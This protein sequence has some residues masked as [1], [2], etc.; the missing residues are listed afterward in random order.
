MKRSLDKS[1]P[2]D[3]YLVKKFRTCF[4]N[5]FNPLDCFEVRN[6]TDTNI[7]P[8]GEKKEITTKEQDSLVDKKF[9]TVIKENKNTNASK[10][11][12]QEVISENWI[13]TN[14]NNNKKEKP[15]S[16]LEKHDENNQTT[17]PIANNSKSI[18]KPKKQKNIPSEIE[19]VT[20]IPNSDVT[21]LAEVEIFSSTPDN[22]AVLKSQF[23]Q[24]L[25]ESGCFTISQLTLDQ[26]FF[27]YYSLSPDYMN[28]NIMLSWINHKMTTRISSLSN[29]IKSCQNELSS[30]E[31]DS[32][33]NSSRSNVSNEINNRV[34]HIEQLVKHYSSSKKAIKSFLSQLHATFKSYIKKNCIK[35]FTI[36]SV[37]TDLA[38]LSEALSSNFTTQSDILKFL[39]GFGDRLP[40]FHQQEGLLYFFWSLFRPHFLVGKTCI[41]MDTMG[42]GKT[43]QA[44]LNAK[45][46]NILLG[47]LNCVEI[48]QD[49]NPLSQKFLHT[50]DHQF[51]EIDIGN[52]FK[53]WMSS[54]YETN[55]KHYGIGNR[56]IKLPKNPVNFSGN[57]DLY[58]D[59]LYR[60]ISS[61]YNLN[62]EMDVKLNAT[63]NYLTVCSDRQVK[64]L[65]Q[66]LS[67]TNEKQ[68]EKKEKD[69]STSV[70]DKDDL[71]KLV[72]HTKSEQEI[73][74]LLMK[75]ETAKSDTNLKDIMGTTNN[76]WA[77]ISV[78]L[79]GNTV[80]DEINKDNDFKNT[81]EEAA[82][83]FNK[84][85]YVET[86]NMNQQ[87]IA[88][89]LK[90]QSLIQKESEINIEQDK[91]NDSILLDNDIIT[92][93]FNIN[94]SSKFTLPWMEIDENTKSYKFNSFD[95]KI[96]YIQNQQKVSYVNAI[97]TLFCSREFMSL[98]R[99]FDGYVFT[100][101]PLLAKKISQSSFNLQEATHT[102][103]F[104]E[105]VEE[106]L[107]SY[108]ETLLY[109]RT[110]VWDTFFDPK[111]IADIPPLLIVPLGSVNVWLEEI[112]KSWDKTRVGILNAQT[113]K[114]DK[115]NDASIVSSFLDDKFVVK[116]GNDMKMHHKLLN[117]L[118][119]FKSYDPDVCLIH[120][121]GVKSQ[122]NK[123]MEQ[124][125]YLLHI[126]LEIIQELLSTNKQ[127]SKRNSSNSSS[128]QSQKKADF[129]FIR[130]KIS[131][132][133]FAYEIRLITRIRDNL[134]NIQ[135]D[136]K[137]IKKKTKSIKIIYENTH[138]I[139]KGCNAFLNTYGYPSYL[140]N[141]FTKT[142][143][144]DYEI[145]IKEIEKRNI[146]KPEINSNN[147]EKSLG[148]TVEK[149]KLLFDP[150][151]TFR[152][153]Y[154]S[155]LPAF[156]KYI[157]TSNYHL[158]LD[159]SHMIKNMNQRW[160]SI[161]NLPTSFRNFLSGTPFS[162]Y[163]RECFTMLQLFTTFGPFVPR[164]E[165]SNV[166]IQSSFIITI[167]NM[168]QSK[169]VENSSQNVPL[170]RLIMFYDSIFQQ[171]WCTSLFY[172]RDYPFSFLGDRIS[173]GLPDDGKW[174]TLATFFYDISLFSDC[175]N[176]RDHNF[177]YSNNNSYTTT[178]EN[179]ISEDG[180][181][182]TQEV[183]R[184]KKKR[185]SRQDDSS[186]RI[187]NENLRTFIV[188]IIGRRVDMSSCWNLAG[189]PIS[190][191]YAHNSCDIVC[192][193][194][195]NPTESV[196]INEHVPSPLPNSLTNF[197]LEL[198]LFKLT[199]IL[200]SLLFKEVKFNYSVYVKAN[201]KK[202]IKK[203][204][205]DRFKNKVSTL[206]KREYK[207]FAPELDN[208]SSVSCK[209]FTHVTSEIL[210]KSEIIDETSR[211]SNSNNN[212]FT[213]KQALSNS[214]L[215]SFMV[216][217]I[218]Y[219]Y[220][221]TSGGCLTHNSNLL[222]R[223]FI[224]SGKTKS[225]LENLRTISTSILGFD[226]RTMMY[227]RIIR[228]AVILYLKYKLSLS[229]DSGHFT[230]N[231]II[232]QNQA[233]FFMDFQRWFYEDSNEAIKMIDR[234]EYSKNHLDGFLN[235][236]ST[237]ATKEFEKKANLMP[238]LEKQS[239]CS[240]SQEELIFADKMSSALCEE[241]HKRFSES[242]NALGNARK[243]YNFG[244]KFFW[245][246]SLPTPRIF[247]CTMSPEEEIAY[248]Y[249]NTD[250]NSDK[251]LR[252]QELSNLSKSP[253]ARIE[254]KE[255]ANNNL[256]FTAIN[257]SMYVCS[258]YL[259]KILR[260]LPNKYENQEEDPIMD[261][262]EDEDEKEMDS[263]ENN[264]NAQE[265]NGKE[266]DEFDIQE[267]F[268]KTEMEEQEDTPS[269]SKRRNKFKKVIG[270]ASLHVH[271]EELVDLFKSLS[272][273]GPNTL[274]TRDGLFTFS[275]MPSKYLL[276]IWYIL[277]ETNIL[278]YSHNEGSKPK[279]SK[280]GTSKKKNKK[281]DE[282][283]EEEQSDNNNEEEDM[284]VVFTLG[285]SYLDHLASF[286]S[287]FLGIKV[288]IYA[289]SNTERKNFK[290]EELKKFKDRETKVILIS[291]GS[292]STSLNIPEANHVILMDPW[293]N[294]QVEE[295]AK[296]RIARLGQ[297]K[298][299]HY[300]VFTL[301]GFMDDVI[302][303]KADSKA[304]FIS[305]LF[306]QASGV[307]RADV[308]QFKYLTFQRTKIE[309]KCNLNNTKIVY[310][311][312]NSKNKKSAE[313][314]FKNNMNLLNKYSNSEQIQVDPNEYVDAELEEAFAQDA[315]NEAKR[316]EIE[317]NNGTSDSSR[318]KRK[319]SSSK[320]GGNKKSEDLLT[321]YLTS[322]K[323]R[324]E[325]NT[326]KGSHY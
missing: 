136:I 320:K 82:N 310:N 15:V 84:E 154:D 199:K 163:S 143:T 189:F 206:I 253:N 114:K 56:T 32:V 81:D 55:V 173:R 257:N 258:N 62:Q 178:E 64:H 43:F 10:T 197:S 124:H 195:K 309:S 80:E 11:T 106:L 157:T 85:E 169:L 171:Y 236:G 108:R 107:F 311:N 3:S 214:D 76:G 7:H 231:S 159:E 219:R 182:T 251:L 225:A 281:N 205:E 13:D 264:K 129:L 323:R 216:Q 259:S 133:R 235:F 2:D 218:C 280:K 142:F 148:I 40:F 243:E 198:S 312:S 282:D 26:V 208:I 254:A 27:F 153:K 140:L 190:L 294:P 22:T 172:R 132:I 226:Y 126:T 268:N 25:F 68:V 227:Y 207:T 252:L 192:E 37:T 193:V 112:W 177:V 322:T 88:E 304:K 244:I 147:K 70:F 23:A 21:E 59:A 31:Q 91:E 97:E 191:L 289:G 300:S 246:L 78:S 145:C 203:E 5:G 292:G 69:Y 75:Q 302:N 287:R 141:I 196:L 180:Q 77:D 121:N 99:N 262:Q 266:N 63:E 325:L 247:T 152:K 102:S 144:K 92:D 279:S 321:L 89:K 86:D 284:L 301:R 185:A 265:E 319:K 72:K 248:F 285:T 188:D 221:A 96:A 290:D 125:D 24:N 255:L 308:K 65:V 150:V 95:S 275:K 28:H 146:S 45:V 42:V 60:N 110:K 288:S 306:P 48:V 117:D 175:T 241:Y 61:K 87:T 119:D 17:I 93:N 299:L 9:A 120:I 271:S 167:P 101:H 278:T 38:I 296:R 137:N 269:R 30:L 162:N 49:F 326:K 118:S 33:V 44:L 250:G 98:S 36:E 139:L 295:Q 315:E 130:D 215:L 50:S 19:E 297:T 239:D 109:T 274:D 230:S 39:C 90:T 316:A 115:K 240:L 79:F 94:G 291:L 307:K 242:R 234:S 220:Q 53:L 51:F 223:D 71:D 156:A 183:T 52:S 103:K 128:T 260:T 303:Y 54:L 194:C 138:N 41:F 57:T 201:M 209:C 232:Q 122:Y 305:N 1:I 245:G 67:E 233:N 273:K 12:I 213:K 151:V 224:Q 104:L 267:M 35:Q 229:R 179:T 135:S 164:M 211:E 161:A 113:V 204:M 66:Q 324:K 20:S 134:V 73:Q 202:K 249:Y 47:W 237:E 212:G 263:N 187:F 283:S 170:E 6:Y 83:P 256:L 293:W 314:I 105:E 186:Q 217:F 286:V 18:N 158:I 270:Y 149:F 160:K 131:I 184:Y 298:K 116:P 277:N 317:A 272:Y 318:N 228:A 123:L 210:K 276:L 46:Y 313:E 155:K 166:V 168:M 174:E 176:S 261:E 181:S 127:S 34:Q 4:W 74:L 100:L 16:L 8:S 111:M 29:L 200:K 165:L 14:N 58:V 222:Y 238:P